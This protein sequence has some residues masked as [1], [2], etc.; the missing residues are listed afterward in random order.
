MDIELGKDQKSELIWFEFCFDVFSESFEFMVEFVIQLWVEVKDDSVSVLKILLKFEV[1]IVV[2]FS[3]FLLLIIDLHIGRVLLSLL[4]DKVFLF[5]GQIFVLLVQSNLKEFEL[6]Y[7]QIESILTQFEMSSTWIT[8][9]VIL[10][11][12]FS[13]FKLVK[14]LFG[15]VHVLDN[16]YQRKFL[17]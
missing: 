16:S 13:E 9:H 12:N 3:H 5:F 8:S 2:Q 4:E 11:V 1:Q 7:E 14:N 6:I 10:D 15:Q 17:S